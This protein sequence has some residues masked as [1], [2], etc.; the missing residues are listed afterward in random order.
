L[1]KL[2]DIFMQVDHSFEKTHGGLGIGLS[3]AKQLIELH[4]G[5]IDAASDGLGQGS[6]ISVHLPRVD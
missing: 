5:R 2:F 3:I 1:P 6:R 4:G